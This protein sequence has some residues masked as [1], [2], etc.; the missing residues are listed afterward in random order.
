MTETKPAKAPTIQDVARECGV[1]AMTV[2]SALSGRGRVSPE[3]QRRIK[4]AAQALGYEPNP[5][6]RN[7]KAGNSQ[8]I[9]VFPAILIPSVYNATVEAIQ[10]R[11]TPQGFEVP[12]YNY[13]TGVGFGDAKAEA[14]RARAVRLLRPRAITGMLSHLGE[15]A[16][17]EIRLYIRQGG[18]VVSFG[19]R[20][21]LECD[22]IVVDYEDMA[23]QATRHLLELGHRRIGF[24]GSEAAGPH[25]ARLRGFQRALTEFGVTVRPDW[26]WQGNQLEAGGIQSA[27]L[28]LATKE[29]P[30]A[31]VFLYDATA[32]VFI[33]ELARNGIEVP[34]DVSVVTIGDTPIAACWRPALSVIRHPVAE[35]ADAVVEMLQQRLSGIITG[36]ARNRSLHGQLISRESAAPFVA[37][38]S[39]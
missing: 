35:V 14:E 19:R 34:R 39:I 38:S 7:L 13:V 23:F 21:E 18:C 31:M 3:T 15:P 11:L 4:I 27:Q 32:G 22:Q 10:A 37:S 9:V 28:F 17:E 24:Y 6:A 25:N 20:C 8:T 36:P 26:T 1:A 29:K 33:N 2:S 5:H 30:S 12:L 16:L